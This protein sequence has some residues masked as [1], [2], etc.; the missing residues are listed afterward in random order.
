LGRSRLAKLAEARLRASRRRGS[1]RRITAVRPSACVLLA[2]HRRGVKRCRDRAAGGAFPRDDAC[3]VRACNR[4]ARWYRKA[5]GRGRYSR[6][7][8]Q[9]GVRNVSASE[10]PA[11]IL[12]TKT[13]DMRVFLQSPLTDSNRR[14]PPYHP[15]PGAGGA[16]TTGSRRTRRPRKPEDLMLTSDPRVDTRGRADVRISFARD[17]RGFDH[18]GQAAR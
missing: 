2:A 5:P 14:P 4:G 18:I 11:P 7:A 1:A 9:A 13:R 12:T 8:R 6:R 10:T 3:D 15:G 16:G 17:I